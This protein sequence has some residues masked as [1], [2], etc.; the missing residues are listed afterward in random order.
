MYRKIAIIFCCALG[1]FLWKNF[2]RYAVAEEKPKIYTVKSSIE[3]AMAAS[4]TL[5]GIKE[6]L[7]QATSVKNQARAEFLPKLGLSYGY[8]RLDQ[9]PT[10]NVPAPITV[11]TKDNYQFVGTL[12]Q[13]I[14]TGFGLLSSYR[15]SKLGID[16]SEMDIELA[17]LDLALSVKD[18]YYGIL[19]A[20]AGIEVAKKSVESLESAANV[21]RNFHKVGM[22][23]VNDV[24]KAEVDLANSVQALTRTENAARIARSAFNTVLVRDVNAPVEVEDVRN[25][26]PQ[27]DT[28]EDYRKLALANRPEIKL[29]DINIL[30]SDQQ[31]KLAKSKYWPEIALTYNY[32][33]N[34][35]TPSVNGGP[36]HEPATQ[37]EVIVGAQWTFWEWGKTYY[38]QK[39]QESV[40]KELIETKNTLID[41]ITLEVRQAMLE[42]ETAIK[43]I[44]TTE[45]AVKQGEENL[46]VNEER[47]KAQVT[48]I[49][50]L[51]D[52][53]RLLSQARVNFYTAIYTTALA[54]ATLDRA[55]GTY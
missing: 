52:A 49:T 44:P 27:I 28:F 34:G 5:K 48:T 18:A 30:K 53:Q 38:S 25:V 37:W 35:D 10:I 31:I 24:L 42:L 33:K 12:T 39:T 43:N 47:Y 3:E 7:N 4:Y 23:P 21:A 45:K 20:D 32:S 41:N 14:F 11:G 26:H 16:Q 9:A 1:F 55:I 2:S 17:K 13:P 51:L 54:K 40:K 36:F 29:I 22:V 6:R 8:T 50:E 19:I 15:L 46:R